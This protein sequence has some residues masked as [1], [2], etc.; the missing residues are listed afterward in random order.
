[1]QTLPSQCGSEISEAARPLTI[2]VVDD[3][4]AV[5]G[6]LRF[7]LETEGFT[8]E[9]F[10]SG[11]ALLNSATVKSADCYVIDYKMETMNGLDVAAHLRERHIE[12]PIILVT[13]VPDEGIS[14]KATA[15]GAQCVLLK[16]HLEESLAAHI[17]AAIRRKKAPVRP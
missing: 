11:T 17:H 7:L 5:L 6:S 16:P 2:D 12:T 13:G 15:A 3:D 10:R 1:M 14:A 9:T 8:V 4:P